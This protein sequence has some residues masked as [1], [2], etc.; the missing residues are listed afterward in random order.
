MTFDRNPI[1]TAKQVECERRALS[2][3]SH[4]AIVRAREGARALWLRET[5]ASADQRRAFEWAFEEVMFGA[6]MWTMTSDPQHPAVITISRL[7]HRL[8]ELAVPGSRW[9]L[10][11][12]DTVYRVIAI[13]GS[14]RY[15]IR[16]RVP[17]RRLA[18]NYFTL[19]DANMNTIDVLD[20]KKLVLDVEGAFTISIDAD[21]AGGRANHIRSS[22]A[23]KELYIRDVLMNWATDLVNDLEVEK[24]GAPK[25]PARTDDE[26]AA[27]AAA[28]MPDYVR[29]TIRW[30]GQALSKPVNEFAFTIDRD[31]DGALRNQIYV[32]GQFQVGDDEAL[33]IDLRTGGAEYFIV[34]V[35]NQWGTT[36]GIADRTGSLNRAQSVANPDGTYTFVISVRDPGVHNWIDPSDLHDGILTLRWA[37]FPGGRPGADLGVSSRLVKLADLARSLP[38]GTRF[39]TAEE[40]RAQLRQRAAEYAWRLLER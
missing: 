9:G 17:H 37:E 23:A 11:N 14:E 19:W 7:P 25:T 4:A 40:R 36:N 32:L 22:A 26:L 1:H 27:L 28:A 33:V 34:P 18:E 6:L 24:L 20:G 5:T 3:L 38:A 21:P 29:K 31:T 12:P 35:T 2:L 8:G 16:G 39:V 13:D 30:N 10:D 15:L